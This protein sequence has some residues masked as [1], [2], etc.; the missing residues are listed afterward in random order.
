MTRPRFHLAFPVHDLEAA[1][2]FYAG[3]LGCRTGRESASWIDFDLMGHQVVA[4]L[5]PEECAS[6]RAGAVDGQAIPVR[7]FGLIVD[8]DMFDALAAR[9]QDAG[10]RFIIEPYVRF[11]GKPGEQKTLFVADPSGN[12]LEFKAFREDDMVFE[13]DGRMFA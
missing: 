11:A 2:S 8:W 12:A 1:R 4:H 9:L 3:V 10:A 13:T 5:A 7:H 6:V